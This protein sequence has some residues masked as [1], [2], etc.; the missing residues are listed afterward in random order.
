MLVESGQTG[1]R[2]CQRKGDAVGTR[3]RDCH[4]LPGHL[5]VCVGGLWRAVHACSCQGI[6]IMVT[7]DLERMTHYSTHL[8]ILY[9]FKHIALEYLCYYLHKHYLKSICFSILKQN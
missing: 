3:L 4:S 1:P 7:S 8:I 9:N 6:L 2:F 5:T